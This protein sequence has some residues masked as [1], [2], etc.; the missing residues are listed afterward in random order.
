MLRDCFSE[1]SI[2]D[3]D[4]TGTEAVITAVS[5]QMDK[6]GTSTD[7]MAD[8]GIVVYICGEDN[9]PG[10]YELDEQSRISDLLELCG[11]ATDHA[12][13]EAV[14][15]AK[16]IFDGE[17]VYIPSIDEIKGSGIS[18]SEGDITGSSEASSRLI[19]IN[20]A[21]AEE[22]KTLPGIGDQIA[23]NIIEHRQ[24]YGPFRSKEE[25]KNV[26]GIGEKKYEQIKELISV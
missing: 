24:K 15:L 14:N 7:Y 11:G 5:S 3:Q 6:S 18:L 13:L 25:L 12:C 21:S 17:R 20:Q 23:N 10:V 16:K 9:N 22:L 2:K 4:F 26:N 19:N 1:V 8:A